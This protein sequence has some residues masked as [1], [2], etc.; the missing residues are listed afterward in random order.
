M[1]N[2]FLY[3]ITLMK[4]NIYLL[5]FIVL[6]FTSCKDRFES[7]GT[8]PSSPAVRIFAR[9]S[10]K[11]FVRDSIKLSNPNFNY[12]GIELRLS[13]SDKYYTSLTYSYNQ[14]G[15]KILYRHDTLN[16]NLL[17]FDKDLCIVRFLPMAEGLTRM[18]FTATDQLHNSN[19]STLELLAFKNLPPVSM[20][21]VVP[22]Q[23]IDPLEY[24]M[25]ASSSYDPDRHFGGGISQYIYQ[26][27]GQ[28]ITSSKNQIKHIFS[29]PGVYT[30]TLQTRD[31]D[32]ALSTVSSQQV[33]IN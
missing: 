5:F 8:I 24:L 3:L 1:D 21:K 22:V 13:D 19:S 28:V 26:V 14:G 2:L 30:I 15:G 10:L 9:D 11:S 4:K 32:G 6:I 25:D 29:A 27:D 7:I 17:P 12:Y 20:L 23:I 31:N 33:S 16:V 18:V